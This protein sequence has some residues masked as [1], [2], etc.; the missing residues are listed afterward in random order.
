MLPHPSGCESFDQYS[1]TRGSP[2]A[3]EGWGLVNPG[4]HRGGVALGSA[5]PAC[6]KRRDVASGE[7][8]RALFLLRA[9]D[10]PVPLLWSF[11]AP[12]VSSGFFGP[13]AQPDR[14]TVS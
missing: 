1:F 4:D 14:A 11:Q 10:Y 2:R 9:G 7:I 3:E 8:K 12:A 5:K 6:R 13:V